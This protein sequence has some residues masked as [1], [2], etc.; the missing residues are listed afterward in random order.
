[1]HVSKNSL[2]FKI[3]VKLYEKTS[4]VNVIKHWQLLGLRAACVFCH[5][6]VDAPTSH[7][8]DIMGKSIILILFAIQ[9]S[10]RLDVFCYSCKVSILQGHSHELSTVTE[11][12]IDRRFIIYL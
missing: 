2:S 12:N 11:R 8:T 4:K 10:F 6:E 3:K 9:I 7:L 1:M 5:S